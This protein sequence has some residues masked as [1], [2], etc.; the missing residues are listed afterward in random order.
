MAQ[1]KQRRKVIQAGQYVRAIQY[2]MNC[3]PDLRRSRA[4]KETISSCARE[5]LN[6]QHSWQ[7]LKATL[8]ANFTMSDLVVTLTYS[9]TSLPPLRRDAEN[10]LKLFIRYLRA[11]RRADGQELKYVYVTESG[12][13]HG[14][15]HHHLVINSSGKDYEIIRALWKWGDNIDF[16]HV[17]TKGYDG[18]SRYLAKE[19]REYGRRYVGERMWRSSRGLAK[20]QVISGWV[21]A[22][23]ELRAPPE[24]HIIDRQQRVNGYGEFT[25]L[26]YTLPPPKIKQGPT[27]ISDL[28]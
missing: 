5:A 27:F 13:S 11:A 25:Y 3:D 21:Q 19:P 16:R 7:K 15:L 8:A 14:R 4:P 2:T 9:D 17:W 23:E 18:W 1:K 28:G 12:H 6:L 26:E 10:H 24:A 22:G 20:P